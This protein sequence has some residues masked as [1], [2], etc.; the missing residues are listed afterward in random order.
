V[1]LPFASEKPI[2]IDHPLSYLGI[3]AI[4]L[5]GYVWYLEERI[6][7]Q[8]LAWPPQLGLG[9]WFAAI[10]LVLFARGVFEVYEE[11]RRRLY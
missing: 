8:L 7:K 1:T 5:A 3:F 11:R 10:G 2:G 9:F 4:L 6:Q